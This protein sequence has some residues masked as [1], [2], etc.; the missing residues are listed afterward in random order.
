MSS[1]VRVRFAPSPTGYLHVGG[2]RTALFN[3]L[4]AR[5]QGGK[6]I[7]RIE[8]TDEARNTPEAMAAILDGMR[9]LGL[10]WD[11]GPE[12]GGAFGPY[13]QSQRKSIYDAY[14]TKLEKAGRVYT[15]ENGA[16]RFTFSRQP[17][18]IRDLV[19]GDVALAATEEPDMTVRRPDGSYIFHFVNV[20][21]DI[22][23]GV[24]HVI[25][26]EDHLSN[27]WKHMDLFA[28]F[29]KEPP[30]YAHIPLILNPDGTKMSKRDEGSAV[31][32]YQ[33]EGFLAKAVFNYLCM[34]GW[35]PRAETEKLSATEMAALF[36]PG[37][38][39]SANA[40]FDHK[41]CQW[42]N[43]QY[44]RELPEDEY[45]VHARPFLVKAGYAIEDE[46]IAAKAVYSVKEKI[47]LFKELPEWVHYFF[48]EDYP[49]EADVVQKLK[50]KPE[51]AALLE[52]AAIAIGKLETWDE[53]A[54]HNAVES[55]AI[56]MGAKPGA[57]MPLLRFALTGQARGPGVTT[58]IDLVGQSRTLGRIGRA[59]SEVINS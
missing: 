33:E 8:D 10:D 23:M 28:A 53:A 17:M 9:W 7:L 13:F 24:T 14:M 25:R 37:Q 21:D 46:G 58:I 22:E 29:G 18:T 12:V 48:R 38:I 11:E 26:G 54:I 5:S 36:D 34:L 20:V 44:L 40:R 4:F 31:A 47:S 41:K 15:E 16:V 35:T 59:V 27:T 3:W 57:L 39:H 1:P 56:S 49:F 2:A 32:S 30:I 42:F 55:A 6:L 50:A 45:Y 19:C 52:A 51:N 43:A